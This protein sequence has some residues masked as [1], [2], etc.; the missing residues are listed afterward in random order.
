MSL[1]RERGNIT[2]SQEA[3]KIIQIPKKYHSYTELST[4]TTDLLKYSSL[5]RQFCPLDKIHFK[6]Q[7]LRK[8]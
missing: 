6:Q 4:N 2:R 1:D 7:L 3:Q 8:V 5:P